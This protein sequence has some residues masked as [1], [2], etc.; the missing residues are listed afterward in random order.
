MITWE[1]WR[2]HDPSEAGRPENQ[3]DFSLSAIL[4]GKYDDYIRNWAIDLKNMPCQVFF[5]PMHEMNGNW[6][7]WSGTV[8]GN[9]PEEYKRAWRHIRS[10]FREVRNERLAWVWSPYTHSVPDEAGNELSLYYPGDRDV[11]WLGLDGYNWGNSRSWSRWQS[12]LDI[13][14]KG[15]ECLA[16]L[17]PGKPLMIAETGCTEEGGDKG[18]W[19]AETWE[20]LK[21][22]FPRIKALIW[23][24]I[25]KECDWRVDSSPESANSFKKNWGRC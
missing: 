6:Y 12:F 3:P 23:F 13:F 17:A 8:N 5:R 2:Y 1:P 7:P 11:D 20:T 19:I 22:R 9:R 16:K 14:E 4:D 10:I 24:N 18:N 25:N 15:Y 21:D